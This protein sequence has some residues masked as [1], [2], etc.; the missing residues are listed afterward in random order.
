MYIEL[1]VNEKFA[2]S[3]LGTK[4]YLMKVCPLFLERERERER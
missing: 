4:E 3:S 1:S 2:R